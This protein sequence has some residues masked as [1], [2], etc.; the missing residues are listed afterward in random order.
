MLCEGT[1]D[2]RLPYIIPRVQR[3]FVF[4]LAT[5]QITDNQALKGELNMRKLIYHVACSTDGFIAH[6]DHTVDGFLNEGRHSADYQESL[7]NDYEIALMGRRTYEFG[8]QFGVTSPYPWLEQYVIS[9]TMEESPDPDVKLISENAPSF[10]RALKEGK[11]KNIYLCGGAVLAGTLFA[12][13]LVDELALKLNPVLFGSD[14]PLFSE[15]VSQT[16][17]ELTDSKIY[18]N[19]VALLRYRVEH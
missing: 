13:G 5:K 15:V 18:H 11:G 8:L 9:R 17:L 4:Q 7:R 16:A 14:I 1:A 10:V 19:G 6:T 2:T 3:V 12:E